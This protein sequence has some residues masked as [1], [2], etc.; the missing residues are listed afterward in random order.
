MAKKGIKIRG[1]LVGL[2]LICAVLAYSGQMAQAQEIEDEEDT[3]ILSTLMTNIQ[4]P[5][6]A[7]ETVVFDALFGLLGSLSTLLLY[8]F[9]II[10]RAFNAFVVGG[11]G[12]ILTLIT[13]VIMTGWQMLGMIAVELWL[14]VK[15]VVGGVLG[16]IG[17]IAGLIP[18]V[19]IAAGIVATILHA[20]WLAIFLIVYI[21][22]VLLPILI[23]G[24]VVGAIA[25]WGGTNW[26]SVDMIL[27]NGVINVLLM[28]GFFVPTAAFGIAGAGTIGW[29]GGVGLGFE[30]L[31]DVCVCSIIELICLPIVVILSL[32]LFGARLYNILPLTY[33]WCV[34]T[35]CG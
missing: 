21:V 14:G 33:R 25:S 15:F 1:F 4:R 28:L 30:W 7:L 34:M 12:L 27:G 13:D 22:G 6:T 2:A 24:V 29:C 16:I 17:T 23:D 11:G 9:V 31:A 20:I 35:C 26:Y 32:I 19:G 8:V 10:F 3:S 18:V 5:V